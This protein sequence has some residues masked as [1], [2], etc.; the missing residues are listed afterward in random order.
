MGASVQPISSAAMSSLLWEI[1]SGSATA[2]YGASPFSS[3]EGASGDPVL[4]GRLS[5]AIAFLRD[6]VVPRVW[7]SLNVSEITVVRRSEAAIEGDALGVRWIEVSDTVYAV[8]SGPTTETLERGLLETSDYEVLIPANILG[9]P[10]TENDAVV[11]DSAHFDVVG[12]QAHPKVPNAVAYR[13][14]CKRAA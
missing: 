12:V 4:I 7:G 11:I 10:L 2:L 5:K 13:Y 14:W 6:K 3:G 1:D 9:T 8:I